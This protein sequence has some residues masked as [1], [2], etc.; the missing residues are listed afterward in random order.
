[1]REK[2][3]LA[4]IGSGISGLTVAREIAMQLGEKLL[5]FL[6]KQVGPAAEWQAK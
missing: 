2:I 4:V 1:M 5:Q 6:K 3:R